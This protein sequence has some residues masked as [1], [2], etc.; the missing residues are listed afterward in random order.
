MTAARR[1][2]GRFLASY[3]VLYLLPFPASFL[4]H[5][6]PLVAAWHSCWNRLVPWLAS[7]L[8]HLSITVLPNG[9]GDTTFNYFQLPCFVL[10]ALAAAAVWTLAA[11]GEPDS[12][13]FVRFYVRF[14]LGAVLIGYGAAKFFNGQ[15]PA[16]DGARLI[17][18][19]GTTS[20]MGLLWRFMGASQAYAAFG[21]SME[22]IAGLLLFWRRTLLA[23]SLTAMAVLLNVV[24]L[25]FAYDVPV[26]IYSMHLFAMA[27]YLAAPELPE[28]A[29]FLLRARPKAPLLARTLAFALAAAVVYQNVRATLARTGPLPVPPL[30]GAYTVEELKVAA[31]IAR[32]DRWAR[33]AIRNKFITVIGE[34]GSARTLEMGLDLT[35]R[36]IHVTRPEQDGKAP[37][38]IALLDYQVLDEQHLSLTG[39]LGGQ[40]ASMTLRKLG[41]DTFPLLTRGF[42]WINEFP[43]SR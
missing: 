38:T 6:A 36:L 37:E 16:P 22:I 8:F 21:G 35:N 15:F 34:D 25:N 39:K 31:A 1:L 40:P 20:P 33:V 4:P 43:Y 14:G 17:Q 13:G 32:E 11:R 18:P 42:H 12:R 7:H 10:L 5:G 23:G 28:L 24:M 19:V 2:V 3:F 9:S 26:K 30:I 29:A 41:N 27:V